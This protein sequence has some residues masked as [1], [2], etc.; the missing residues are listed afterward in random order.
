MQ[1]PAKTH[2]EEASEPIDAVLY[3]YIS[4]DQ[5]LFTLMSGAVEAFSNY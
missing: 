4:K 1:E 2:S 5:N 3:L